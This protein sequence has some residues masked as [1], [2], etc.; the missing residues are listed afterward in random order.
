MKVLVRLSEEEIS[1]DFYSQIVAEYPECGGVVTFSGV[2][3]NVN[4]GKQVQSIE[5]QSYES[6]A[7]KELKK[8]A[9]QAAE[10][11]ALS[12]VTLIHRLGKMEIGEMA[13]WVQTIAPH[14][15]EAF[16][17]NQ[18]T[19]NRLKKTVPIW[20]KETYTDG[21]HSWPVCSEGH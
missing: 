5:Y 20:K 2:I 17:A 14:R 4:A 7:Y 1:V 9:H 6:L 15:Q 18:F 12:H 21:T 8:I 19:M 13:V 11:Y 3:R 10:A 16:Q